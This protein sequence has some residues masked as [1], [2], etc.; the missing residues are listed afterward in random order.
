[1]ILNVIHACRLVEISHPE[2]CK[3]I[4]CLDCLIFSVLFR[5]IF[6]VLFKTIS[7]LFKTISIYMFIF[8]NIYTLFPKFVI[9]N[10]TLKR[11]K[12]ASYRLNL[13][14]IFTSFLRY[15]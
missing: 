13:E 8:I 1:M 9:N 4:M 3:K 14:Q 10:P 2:H 11:Y 6:S 15:S 5:T 12:V 7:V